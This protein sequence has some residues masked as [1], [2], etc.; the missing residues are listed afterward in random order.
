M[1]DEKIYQRGNQKHRSEKGRQDN[2]QKKK[3][4]Q[5]STNHYTDN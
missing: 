2:G 1:S 3:Y 5:R 4:K